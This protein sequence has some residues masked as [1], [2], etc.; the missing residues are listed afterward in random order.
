MDNQHIKGVTSI[1]NT[2]ESVK[3]LADRQQEVAKRLHIL[4]CE[5]NEAVEEIR[6]RQQEEERRKL[7]RR[8]DDQ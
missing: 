3:E 8:K 1:K 2:S 4:E 6:A 5:T 7:K